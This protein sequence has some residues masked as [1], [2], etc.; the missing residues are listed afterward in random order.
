MLAYVL[1][2]LIAEQRDDRLQSGA[3]L[4]QAARHHQ[5]RPRARSH[6]HPV[7]PR[8][9]PHPREGF[10]AGDGDYLVDQRPVSGEDPGDEPVRYALDGVPAGLP[11]QNGARLVRLHP[12]ELHVRIDFAEGLA[13]AHERATGSHA[14]HQGLRDRALGQLR[15]Y[16]RPEPD[17]IFL[18]VPLRLEL[19]RAEISWLL[20][21]LA[22]LRERLVDVEVPHLQHLGAQRPAYGDPLAAHPLGHHHQ[23]P[24]ALRGCHHREGVAR[25]A[26]SC[27][28]YGVARFKETLHFGLLDHVLGDSSLDRAR[29]VQ[30]LQLGPNAVDLDQRRIPYRVEHAGNRSPHPSAQG[31]AGARRVISHHLHTPF[32]SFAL[33]PH[34]FHRRIEK[35]LLGDRGPVGLPE[36]LDLEPGPGLGELRRYPGV[37]DAPPDRVPIG[38]ARHVSDRRVAAPYRL[39]AHDHN[40]RV[41]EQE[42]GELLPRSLLFA[43]EQRFPADEVVLVELPRETEPRLVGVVLGDHVRPPH[44][45]ALHQ[46]QAVEGP[47]T[48]GDHAEGL[49][50]LPQRI[51]EP[52]AH[53][54]RNIDLPP[55]LPHVG[56]AQRGDRNLAQV[57]PPGVEETKRLVRKVILGEAL[58]QISSRRTPHPDATGTTGDV[59][60]PHRAVLRQVALHPLDVPRPVE[61]QLEVVLPEASNGYVAPD[62]ARL[63]E[64]Q[65]VGYLAHGF[66]ELAGGQSLEELQGAGARDLRLLERGHVEEGDPLA[67]C[68]VLRPDDW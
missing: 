23:H 56:D 42:A 40:A 8:Y 17:V 21:Q 6:E 57:R 2:A 67:G 37:G 31:P 59:P 47:T 54:R 43:P 63:V 1:L 62:A 12:D 20:S 24:V 30:V 51:P 22:R 35:R 46:A 44:P 16:L 58:H 34:R 13:D 68:K 36:V 27:F 7:L 65:R 10:L 11:A 52:Q 50:C 48:P 28:D 53:I 9:A 32:A 49:P 3:R 41:V 33:A 61:P 15:Q 55:E 66:V 26:A 25:V 19:R 39:V 14:H 38:R 18:H 45:V 5:V 29:R 64:H 60:H 4:L